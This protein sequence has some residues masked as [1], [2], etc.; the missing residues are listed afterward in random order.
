M[1]LEE[2]VLLSSSEVVVVM[3]G[4]EV[5]DVW[6]VEVWGG[7]VGEKT[8]VELEE[9]ISLVVCGKGTQ[10]PMLKGAWVMQ[11]SIVDGSMVQSNAA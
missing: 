1:V 9:G 3:V 10:K 8:E 11:E 2:E 6:V 5:V 7:E 4:G